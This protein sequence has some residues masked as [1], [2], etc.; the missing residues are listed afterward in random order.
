MAGIASFIGLLNPLNLFFYF[1][2]RE[3]ILEYMSIYLVIKMML[4]N[5]AMSIYL[6]KTYKNLNIFYHIIFSLLYSFSGYVLQYYSNINW[7]D[8][9]ILFP[10]LILSLNRLLKSGKYGYYILLYMFCLISSIYV[11]YGNHI[12]NNI[13]RCILHNTVT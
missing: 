5:F 11:I 2:P 9:T 4:S 7:L 8:F 10:L 6:S 1:V 13:C 3:N 12:F